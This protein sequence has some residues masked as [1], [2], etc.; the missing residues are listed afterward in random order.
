MGLL[1][2][3]KKKEEERGKKTFEMAKII[4][5]PNKEVRVPDYLSKPEELNWQVG[6][7]NLPTSAV[8]YGVENKTI[9]EET[10]KKWLS[11]V[12]LSYESKKEKDGLW[13]FASE[14]GKYEANIDPQSGKFGYAENIFSKAEVKSTGVMKVEENKTKLRQLINSFGGEEIGIEKID[15]Q[16]LVSPRWVSTTAQRAQVV[17]IEASYVIN[18]YPVRGYGGNP[19]RARYTRE[20]RLIKLEL[21]L[22]YGKWEAT[23]EEETVTLS[24]LKKAEPGLFKVW[25]VTGSQ[26]YQLKVENEIIKK[27]TLTKINLGYVY[28]RGGSRLWPYYF[29][30]GNSLTE[31]GGVKVTV[32]FPATKSD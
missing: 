24:E 17:E 3:P 10:A 26:D 5:Y 20:G 27:A 30:E 21:E 13:L 18:G 19:I 1:L 2:W 11:L 14:D 29:I 8:V 12:G 22:A 6:E 23:K 28:D 15:Y 9:D 7:E 16:E 25:Q 31:S 32:I 4:D